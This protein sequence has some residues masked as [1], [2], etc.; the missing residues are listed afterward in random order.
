M[1]MLHVQMVRNSKQMRTSAIFL[2]LHGQVQEGLRRRHER[3]AKEQKV[4][5]DIAAQHPICFPGEEVLA[6]VTV[7]EKRV[8]SFEEK[9][10]ADALEAKAHME[11]SR[12]LPEPL[13]QRSLNQAFAQLPEG[14]QA[15]IEACIR[16][17]RENKLAAS[18]VISQVKSFSGSSAVLRGLFAAQPER[19]DL[20]VA[21]P[22]QMRELQRLTVAW[23]WCCT[24]RGCPRVARKKTRQ[25]YILDLY[26]L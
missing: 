17:W 14:A 8:V 18:D 6:Q 19:V 22:A 23:L 1:C 25:L 9:M 7:V 13:T 3:D 16:C 5:A 2:E 10:K 20:E 11:A 12:G 26:M 15:S 21:T 24:G 4:S